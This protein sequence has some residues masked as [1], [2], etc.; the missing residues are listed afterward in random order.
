MASNS[1]ADIFLFLFP[2]WIPHAKQICQNAQLPQITHFFV[3]FVKSG[4]VIGYDET[5]RHMALLCRF[6]MR[7]IDLSVI[8]VEKVLHNHKQPACFIRQILIY[9]VALNTQTSGGLNN[10]NVKL[11]FLFDYLLLIC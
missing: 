6:R 4:I 7:E 5:C 10:R 1:I 9:T 11:V 2:K 3:K 8:D